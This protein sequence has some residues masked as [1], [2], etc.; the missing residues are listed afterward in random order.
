MSTSLIPAALMGVGVS[1]IFVGGVF[2]AFSDF[3]MR[4][5]DQAGDEAATLAMQGINRTVLRSVFLLQFFLLLPAFSALAWWS[6][7]TGMESRWL[8]AA[9]A[10]VYALGCFLVTVAGNVPM[11]NRLAAM[12]ASDA[13][14]S[15]YWQVY[16]H[17]WTRLNHVRTFAC[18]LAGVGSLLAVSPL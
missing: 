1:S 8:I 16:L 12:S 13:E 7:T 15:G 5:L 11:N 4:G 2:L 14:N 17:R 10:L 3:V 18:L 6:W 9:S